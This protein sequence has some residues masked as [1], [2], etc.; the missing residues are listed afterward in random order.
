M[1][2]PPAFMIK[3]NG[4]QMI[5]LRKMTTAEFDLYLP[6]AIEDYARDLSDNHGYS[7]AVGRD[8]AAR[9]MH[10]YLPEGPDTAD[11][12]L[13]CIVCDDERVGYLWVSLRNLPEAYICDFSILPQWRRRGYGRAALTALDSKL[14]AAGCKEVAL[15][16]SANNP[17]AR[18]LYESH[19]FHLTGYTMARQLVRN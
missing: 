3:H 14:M 13:G 2:T 1:G 15:R 17:H 4:K 11:H 19:A 10:D 5:T 18:A 16:V 7:L 9:I 8:N 6:G 12:R